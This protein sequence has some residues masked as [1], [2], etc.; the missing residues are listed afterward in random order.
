MDG[1]SIDQAK[2]ALLMALGRLRPGDRFNVIEFNSHSTP[3][4]VAPM[5][6]DPATL[7]RAKQFVG[8]LRLAVGW[9]LSRLVP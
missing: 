1:V 8:S 7:A 5:P 9:K 3:L 4:F 6:V 2:E